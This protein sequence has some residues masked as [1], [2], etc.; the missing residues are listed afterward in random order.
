M[1]ESTKTVA[2]GRS[3]WPHVSKEQTLFETKEKKNEKASPIKAKANS[4]I[5]A[6]SRYCALKKVFDENYV[7]LMW[8]NEGG[9]TRHETW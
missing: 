4:T 3:T 5:D 7:D 9:G 6:I 2:C 1:G 8:F